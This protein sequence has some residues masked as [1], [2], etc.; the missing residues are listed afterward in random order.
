MVTHLPRNMR[1][2]HPLLKQDSLY[3]LLII[4]NDKGIGMTYTAFFFNTNAERFFNQ[5]V[6]ALE[7][8]QAGMAF[9]IILITSELDCFST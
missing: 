7:T 6:R 3:A 4:S 9:V 1:L 5:L 2:Y 8:R